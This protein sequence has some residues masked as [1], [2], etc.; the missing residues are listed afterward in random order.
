[1]AVDLGLPDR[2][3]DRHI[4]PDAR[5]EAEMLRAVG[6]ASLDELI[7]ETIPADIRF[8]GA[9][10]LPAPVGEYELLAELRA[11]AAKNEV[12]KSFIGMGY[13]DCITPPVILRNVLE[14]PGWYTQ[15]TPYQAEISQGR[16]EALLN[17]QTMV[18]DLTGLP[19][20]NASLLDEATAAAE[21]MHM[22]HGRR[23]RR[24]RPRG[25]LLR[26]ATAATRRRSTS[27]GRAPRPLGIEVVVG[28][29][30]DLRLRREKV[31]GVLAA[32]SRRPT[33]RVARLRAPSSSGRT[34]PARWSR[35]RAIC[36]R[37]RCSTP[38]GEL[39]ADVAVGS[40]QRFGVPLGYGGP[41]AAFF[42]TRDRVR[43]ASCRAA[44]SASREDAHGKPRAAHGA[45]DARAAHPPREG[46]Q[47]HLHGAGAAG[48]HRGHVRRLPRAA[49]ARARSPSA[50]HGLAAVLAR[51]LERL[52]VTRRATS[53]SS[54][55]CASTA[56][57]PRSTAGCRRP[58]RGKMNLR[59]LSSDVARRSRSTRRRRAADVD[60][61]LEVFARDGKARRAH[62]SRRWRARRRSPWGAA[63]RTSAYLTHPVFN[64]HHSE[65]EMLRYMRRLEAR[66]LSLAHVDDPARLLHDEAERDRRDDAD[67]LAGVGRT[68]TRSRRSS[69]REGYQAI[70]KRARARCSAEITGFAGDVAAAERRRAGRVRRAAR[71]PRVSREPRRRDTAT[72][73]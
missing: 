1:M 42:A 24:R 68:C 56:A 21:A 37:S 66:D 17:F 45:A 14:N 53:A 28:D 29:H 35:W 39:G 36:W 48:R 63:A 62:A 13:S 34:R 58:R 59:R 44:S 54:T 6:A 47:Q 41:H 20:A 51:G 32:V 57:P 46:D 72:S 38:P 4:G 5:E 67:H 2:F 19:I 11:L 65:T 52:G 40:A 30:G 60:A 9:L 12:W 70:F 22:L 27:C 71:H 73:A 8:A 33:A 16:L 3:V 15:Y 7:D 50:S 31:F 10:D 18:S 69:R 23:R 49:R 61:L 43:R 26:L 25:A 55:R 64:T